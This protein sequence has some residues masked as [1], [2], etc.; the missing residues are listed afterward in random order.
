M[1]FSTDTITINACTVHRTNA[2]T[3]LVLGVRTKYSLI[4]SHLTPDVLSNAEADNR[5]VEG[6]QNAKADL[7][8]AEEELQAYILSQDEDTSNKYRGFVDTALNGGKP[9]EDARKNKK[10]RC[11]TPM[12]SIEILHA[13]TKELPE[14]RSST[15]TCD[16]E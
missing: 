5:A 3:Y 7:V 10:Q 2:G 14:E 4:L 15:N 1:P 6:L 16:I 9:P 8:A 11:A 12:S 13:D